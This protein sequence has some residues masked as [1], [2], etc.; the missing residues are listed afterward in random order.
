[1]TYGN[2]RDERGLGIAVERV[3]AAR[4]EDG[5]RQGDDRRGSESQDHRT[6]PR[7]GAKAAAARAVPSCV[8]NR[9]QRIKQ[10]QTSRQGAQRQGCDRAVSL[11]SRAVKPALVRLLEWQLDRELEREEQ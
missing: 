7:R 1:M 9:S 3:S 8:S 2:E 4:H 5:E 11:V 10:L 6:A